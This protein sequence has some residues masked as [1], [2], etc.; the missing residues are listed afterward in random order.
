MPT[1]GIVRFGVM[2]VPPAYIVERPYLLPSPII[3]RL[4][5]AS[6]RPPQTEHLL[7]KTSTFLAFIALSSFLVFDSVRLLV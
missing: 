5:L 1:S 2:F 6:R 4:Y 7:P 3:H